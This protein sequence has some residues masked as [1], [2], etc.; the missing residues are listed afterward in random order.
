MPDLA[1]EPRHPLFG[2]LAETP[3]IGIIR[4]CPIAYLDGVAGA[5]VG[6]GISVLEVTMDSP[7]PLRAIAGL[8]ER[9]PEAVIGAGTV[10]TTEE[11][12]SA[13]DAGARFIVTPF[14]SDDV[15]AA[16]GARQ[17]PIVPGAATPTEIQRAIDLGAAAVKVFPARELGGP[18]YVKAIRGPLLDPLLVPTGGVGVDNA[19]AFLEAGAFAVGVG[20]SVFPSA[21][22]A[23]GDSGRVR[24]LASALVEAIA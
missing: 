16:A 20:G 6:A 7:D 21:A 18:D 23:S 9:Q 2:A 22:L 3:V 15:M 8:A 24:S 11:L 19:R 17:I 13:V 4:G 12:G 10:H 5:A 14:L 1:P